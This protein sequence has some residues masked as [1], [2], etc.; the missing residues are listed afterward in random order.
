VECL[1]GRWWKT[2]ETAPIPEQRNSMMI[3]LLG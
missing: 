2:T 1:V 3:D